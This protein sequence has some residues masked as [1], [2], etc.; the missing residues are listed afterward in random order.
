MHLC[1]CRRIIE[2]SCNWMRS[3]TGNKVFMV[4]LEDEGEFFS[5]VFLLIVLDGSA[6]ERG[7]INGSN[8]VISSASVSRYLKTNLLFVLFVSRASCCCCCC[9][10]ITVVKLSQEA[11]CSCPGGNIFCVLRDSSW[12]DRMGRRISAYPSAF[13]IYFLW[14]ASNV[15]QCQVSKECDN[16]LPRGRELLELMMMTGAANDAQC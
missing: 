7:F 6:W 11:L 4:F 12:Q 9:H 8:N 3:V 14:W 13:A 15:C 16:C 10:F 5:A 1:Y 2:I